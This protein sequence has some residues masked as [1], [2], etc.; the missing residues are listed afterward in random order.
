MSVKDCNL[1][2]FK[3]SGPWTTPENIVFFSHYCI[4]VDV[5]QYN[6]T[7][8]LGVVTVSTEHTPTTP[9]TCLTL[10][11]GSA[12][13]GYGKFVYFAR[14][15]STFPALNIKVMKV[16]LG[17]TSTRNHS[18]STQLCYLQSRYRTKLFTWWKTIKQESILKL[19]MVQKKML[20][21]GKGHEQI[22]KKLEETKA[23]VWKKG[24]NAFIKLPDSTDRT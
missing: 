24:S 10:S 18:V 7:L 12:N 21:F 2:L 11:S 13:Y 17:L 6:E 4:F 3:G 19:V 20:L 8:M 23:P 1:S 22:L 15:R 9:N 14:I 16:C 5:H